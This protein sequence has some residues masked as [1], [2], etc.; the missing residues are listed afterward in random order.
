MIEYRQ[1][2]LSDAQAIGLL[3]A[4]SWRENNR[5]EFTDA[6]LYADFLRN[7]SSYGK[8]GSIG[9]LRTSSSR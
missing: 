8:G 1:A 4:R 9:P 5:G 2:R 7:C 6:F 3:H